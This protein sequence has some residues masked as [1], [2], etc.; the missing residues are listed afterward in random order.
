MHSFIHLFSKYLLGSY[1]VQDTI[2][3]N[4]AENKKCMVSTLKDLSAINLG[5]KKSYQQQIIQ[6]KTNLSKKE[7]SSVKVSIRNQT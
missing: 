7:N 2:L 6:L 5:E 4:A 1:H 3:C